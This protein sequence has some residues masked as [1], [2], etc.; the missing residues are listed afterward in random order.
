MLLSRE[1]FM[2]WRALAAIAPILFFSVIMT[3]ESA[4]SHSTTSGAQHQP[5]ERLARMCGYD[6]VGAETESLRHQSRI[7][8]RGGRS[9][10]LPAADLARLSPEGP[11]VEDVGDVA[12]ISDDGSIVLPPNK[13]DLKKRSLLFTPDG[14][15][16]RIE[17]GKLNFETEI[18]YKLGYFFG[19]ESTPVK[20]DNGYR[21]LALRS[22]FS[23]F[24]SLYDRIFVG[25]NG[26]IT[27]TQGDIGSAPSAAAFSS[28]LPRI[29]PLWADLD[30]S[31][32]G[33]IYFSELPG[34]TVI[35]WQAVGQAQ[36][37]GSSTFQVVLHDD[38]RIVFIY[39]KVAARSSLIGISPGVS[40][41][42]L[43]L[44]DLSQPPGD[45]VGGV[46]EL[47][48]SRKRL[49]IPALTLAFYRDH[50]DSFDFIYIWTDFE[51][52]NGIGLAHA[53]NVRNSIKGIGLSVFDRG[54]IYGSAE[55]LSTIVTMGET[56][57]WPADPDARAAGIFSGISI[58]CHE[59]GHRWLAYVRFDADNDIK[60][61]LL[62]RDSSHWSFLADSRTNTEG[63]FSSVMEGN[64]W[65]DRG[66]GVFT[67]IQSSANYFS[68]LDQYLMGLRRADEVGVINY[69]AVNDP[70]K[71]YLRVGTP[72]SNFSVGAVRMEAAVDQIVDREGP[73]IPDAASSPREFRVAFIL[74]TEQ[75][76]ASSTIDT[77]NRYRRSLERYFSVATDRRA[78]LDATL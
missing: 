5:T 8:S 40:G 60:D 39:K 3:G 17:R 20:A 9:G 42:E 56:S 15:G 11:K 46:Y 16:Y 58:V 77:V 57:D 32:A 34:R 27:F 28:Q 49:D 75:R 68:P 36:F 51:F 53:F 21:E 48:S 47:F 62:G 23:F 69:L 7:R 43:Q 35:T 13:F 54:S 14:D 30:P 72:E 55:R 67:S 71:Y 22:G 19:I 33:G 26:Y 73:R 59:L 61:D 18:G 41:R 76:A 64:A 6:P 52:D 37:P 70:S 44:L 63:S 24:G 4:D 25:T 66:D 10:S 65:R 45:Q 1:R 12:V 29:A 50:P 31:T 2:S 38:G 74:L 78:T